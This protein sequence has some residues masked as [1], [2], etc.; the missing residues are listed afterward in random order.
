MLIEVCIQIPDKLDATLA[1]SMWP[2]GQ[3]SAS[4]HSAA[5]CGLQHERQRARAAKLPA[6]ELRAWGGLLLAVHV[7]PEVSIHG[8]V[9][10]ADNLSGTPHGILSQPCPGWSSE[11]RSGRQ[12]L[13]RVRPAR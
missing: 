1:I 10:N 8:V 7:C 2:Q 5:A 13:R 3:R 12:R 9:V 6:R 11:F 4:R